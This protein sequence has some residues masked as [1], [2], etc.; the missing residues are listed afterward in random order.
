MSILSELRRFFASLTNGA[1]PLEALPAEYPAYAI[2]T[3]DGYGVAIEW[4]IDKPVSE[5]FSS[6]HLLSAKTTINGT[7]KNLLI[8]ISN[9]EED[10]NEFASVCAQ[11]VDPGKNGNER[12]KLMD[13][14]IVWWQTWKNLLGNTSS[15]KT[16]YS[17]LCEMLVLKHVLSFDPSAKWTASEAGTHDIES[18][19]HSYEVKSTIVRYGALLTISSQFQLLTPKPLDLY[20]LRV[21]ESPV[22]ISIND[23]VGELTENGY[24]EYILESQLS[25]AHFDKESSYRDKKYSILEKRIYTV[26]EDFPKITAESFKGDVIPHAI[27][28]INYTVDLDGL[29]YYSW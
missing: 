18:E 25:K 10:R 2:R 21:E 12:R 13:D 1:A 9:R 26:N 8:L 29:S 28:A 4:D 7:S 22:G 11:F 20:F 17:V 24:D 3:L 19:N 23:V 6:A 27:V 16:P 15:D 5:Y 14:P